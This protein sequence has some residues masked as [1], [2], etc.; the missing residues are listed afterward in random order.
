MQIR[1]RLNRDHQIAKYVS[2]HQEVSK[3][4]LDHYNDKTVREQELQSISTGDVF[5]EFYRHID[6]IRDHHK[7]YPNGPVEN[8]E[9]SYKKRKHGD[10]GDVAAMNYVDKMFSGEEG[11]GRFFDLVLLHEEYLNLPGVKT[12]R[13][14]PYTQYIDKFDVFTPPE[15]PMKQKEKLTDPYFKYLGSLVSYLEDFMR[16]TR[17]L[18]D[19]DKFLSNIEEEFEDAWND[20]KI[21]GWEQT[22]SENG[23]AE[24]SEAEFWC[25]YCE[26]DFR[27]PNVYQYHLSG[28]KHKKAVE[29]RKDSDEVAED[30]NGQANGSANK[31]PLRLKEK[32]I[33]GREYKVQKLTQAMQTVRSD[34]RANVERK[35][36][37]TERER[38]QELEAMYAQTYEQHDAGE[39]SDSEGDDKIYNPLKLPLAWD[40]KPIPYWLYK[41]HG[42]GVEFNCEICGNYVYMGRRAFDKHFNE[43]RHIHGLKCLGITN[44]GLFR[45][46][47]NIQQA[48]DLWEKTQRDKK[49]VRMANENVVEMEDAEGH[50]MPEKVYYDLQKQGLL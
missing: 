7:R 23:A 41:L 3:R 13:R 5:A 35:Q 47:T 38:Q 16:R 20:G 40:G 33:A 28:N 10:D 12:M 48:I 15:F 43:A 17:P 9:K 32:T 14:L 49:A 22:T 29:A 11:F 45:E 39:D 25:A 34:T 19:L 6:E 21:K 27:N 37:L 44:S 31:A 2:R 36:G 42:L 24:G 26:K 1:E 30:K 8:L 50:V 46:I 4:L 18:E